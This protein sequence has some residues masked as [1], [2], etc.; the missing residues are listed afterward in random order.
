[1]F[2]PVVKTGVRNGFPDLIEPAGIIEGKRGQTFFHGPEI[3]PVS[4]LSMTAKQ[5]S[6]KRPA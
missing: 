2:H 4:G 5:A 6:R 3:R 1:L